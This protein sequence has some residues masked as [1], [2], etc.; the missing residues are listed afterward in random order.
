MTSSYRARRALMLPRLGR[1]PIDHLIR[2]ILA[3]V[4]V[5]VAGALFALA[6][7]PT[8]G[9]AGRVVQQ[10]SDH[11]SAIGAVDDLVFPQFPERSTIYAADGSILATLYFRENRKVIR[12]KQVNDVTRRAVLAIEDTKFYEHRGLDY[13][14]ILR[15]LL[16][17]VR[18]G[19]ITQGA[20]TIT[21]Q[22]V[23][24]RF[25]EKVVG[26]E[27]TLERKVREARLAVRIEQEYT[28]DE[29]L[30]L[31]LNEIYFGRGVYGIGTAAEYY[32]SKKAKDLTLPEA[33][34]LAGLIAAPERYSPVNDKQAALERR[35][36]VLDRMLDVGWITLAEA[37]ETKAAPLKLR[38]NAVILKTR[39]PYWVDYVKGQILSD[40]RFGDTYR[41]RKRALFQGG[42][43]IYTTLDP[44]L[45]HAGVRAIKHHLPN[46]SDPQGAVASV[47]VETGAI[48]ALVGGRSFKESQVNVASG[49]GGSGRQ[50]GSAFKPF[51]LAAAFLDGMPAGKVYDSASGQV[52]DCGTGYPP[53]RVFNADGGGRGFVNLWTATENSIN[54]VFVQL[55]SDVGHARVAQVAKRMGIDSEL[56]PV[57]SLTLGTEEVTPLEMAS[58][59]STLANEGVHCE[60]F[61]IRKVLDRDGEVILHNRHGKCRQVIPAKVANLVV[62]MLQRVVCCGTGTAANLGTWPV[63]G[64]TGTTND[65][66]DAWFVGCTRQ[67]CSGSWVGHLKGRVPMTNVHGITV[68]GGTF[69]ARIWHDFMLTAMRGLPALGFPPPPPPT[70]ALVPNVVGKK[71]ERAEKLLAKANFTAEGERVNSTEPAGTV[72]GQSPGAGSRVEAGSLVTLEVSNGIPPKIR[73]PR[74]IGLSVEKARERLL[75]VGLSV[76]IDRKST[77]EKSR[78]GIVFDQ[79]PN[80]GT[81]VKEG[82]RV[83]IAAWRYEEPGGGNGGG[84]GGGGG[85]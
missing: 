61:G 42:L 76:V 5:V 81:R 82:A 10:V 54:A 44:K 64:K 59:F 33:A 72:V 43:K 1:S 31:Y 27:Q 67:R 15:A 60:E 62:A 35:N 49:Q 55:A 48:R 20:S 77:S 14:G 56:E 58:A 16:A 66:G 39:V 65:Y 19:D 17:N 46:R 8:V 25:P 40:E 32:F 4:V 78:D 18:A 71:L 7:L 68:F 70:Y 57:C 41:L 29:I 2:L 23:R 80:G 21:Q 13:Q 50:S 73:V 51:T 85:G 36:E 12:L 47:D 53:Y 34:L 84:G 11:L 45:Q 24:N 30:E 6:W 22:L 79:S 38:R 69:P 75:A 28:K 37:E 74:V 3:G 52:V 9:S 26:T 63:F 83:V